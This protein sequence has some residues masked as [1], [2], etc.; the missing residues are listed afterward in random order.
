MFFRGFHLGYIGLFERKKN[1]R[2]AWIKRVTALARAMRRIVSCKSL[3]L[4]CPSS[5]KILLRR[6]RHRLK[7]KT[8][9]SNHWDD[10]II[11]LINRDIIA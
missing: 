7:I 4:V 2:P 11:L 10:T 3:F 9:K 8:E 1:I 5:R 6:T